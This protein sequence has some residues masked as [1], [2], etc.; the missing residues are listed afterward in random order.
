MKKV[1]LYGV[2]NWGLGHATRSIPIIRSLIELDYEPI[3][4]SDGDA[5]ALLQTEFPNLDTETF[6][7]YHIQYKYRS[8]LAN[9][10]RYGLGLLRT[11]YQEQSILQKHIAKYQPSYIISDNRYGFYH[12]DIPSVMITHQ[13]RIPAIAQ[14]QSKFASSFLHSYINKFDSC[15]VPDAGQAPNLS[16][17]LSHDMQLDIPIQYIG[18]LSRF[19]PQATTQ[20]YD[21]AF[22]LS[23]PEPQRTY[24][25]KLIRQQAKNL[26][27]KMI[28]ARG[29]NAPNAIADTELPKDFDIIDMADSQT[30]ERII[31]DSKVVVSRAGYTTIMDLV[32]M[33]KPALLIPTPGQPEQEYL[34]AHLA[35]HFSGFR[36][37]AQDD[38]DL[39][40]AL[41]PLPK[42]NSTALEMNWSSK[43][44]E[45]LLAS[46]S[47]KR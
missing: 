10:S 9:V 31:S 44:L 2:L 21:I 34:A 23:G 28:L 25:E 18:A 27:Q 47:D 8:M 43:K 15:W 30:L 20:N 40:I 39:S 24:L 1:V 33:Q 16:G 7:T 35:T 4:C 42:W 5:L 19:H 22:I 46:L 13:L 29:T 45:S 3:I 38:L 17:K 14:W 6:P 37:L 26:P 36:F 11:I 12:S 32:A 41:D